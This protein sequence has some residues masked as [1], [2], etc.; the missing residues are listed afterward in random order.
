MGSKIILILAANSQTGRN[1]YRKTSRVDNCAQP[2]TKTMC[3]ANWTVIEAVD[4]HNRAGCAKN[5][6]TTTW[7]IINQ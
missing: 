3:F 1:D 6:Q 2:N 5:S 4:Q 7:R